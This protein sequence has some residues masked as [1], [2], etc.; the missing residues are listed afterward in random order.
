MVFAI[1]SRLSFVFFSCLTSFEHVPSILPTVWSPYFIFVLSFLSPLA[2]ASSRPKSHLPQG[3]EFPTG[4]CGLVDR[5]SGFSR[6]T[7]F[8]EPKLFVHNPLS[9]APLVP[10]SP[11]WP[12]STRTRFFIVPTT[13]L[14]SPI[15]SVP[16]PTSC[17]DAR[18]FL[19]SPQAFPNR[20]VVPPRPPLHLF[21]CF[22]SS[23]HAEDLV[24]P[25]TPRSL[26]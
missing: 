9:H 17:V 23:C 4:P 25:P 15:V 14:H 12:L 11:C 5:F 8:A 22:F 16:P 13:P 1:R 18:G 19:V 26:A 7:Y 20:R 2:R 10:P 3:F 24:G 21:A 6:Q